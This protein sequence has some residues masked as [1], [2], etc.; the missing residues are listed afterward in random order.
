MLGE[1]EVAPELKIWAAGA[2]IFLLILIAGGLIAWLVR[3]LIRRSQLGGTDRLLGSLFGLARGVL[4]VGLAV[5]VLELI[6]LDQESWWQDARLG[7]L[8]ERVA[9]G[10]RYYAALGSN[11]L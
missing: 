7:P 1:W 5:I 2:V 10:I 3:E 4:L 6:G 8:S 11:Y 9:S